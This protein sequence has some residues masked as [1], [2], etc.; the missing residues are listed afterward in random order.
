M[1]EGRARQKAGKRRKRRERSLLSIFL[2]D[3]FKAAALLA[4]LHLFVVQFSVVRGSSMMPN[5]KDGDRLLVDRLT[6]NLGEVERFDVVI[7]ACPKDT[8]VDYVKRVIGMP[9]DR[10][11]IRRGR[12]YVNDQLLPEPF[13]FVPDHHSSEPIFV[14]DSSYFVLGDNRPVSSDSREGWFVGRQLIKGKVRACVWPVARAK[15]F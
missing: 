6:Y 2:G 3:F 11:V 12:I 1:I 13:T 14:P 8:S 5:I 7:L 15:I 4:L 10:I 9:G